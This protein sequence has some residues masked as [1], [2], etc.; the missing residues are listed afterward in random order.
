MIV[1]DDD[2]A[3]IPDQFHG[4]AFKPFRRLGPGFARKTAPDRRSLNAIGIV[5][6]AKPGSVSGALTLDA[7]FRQG[8]DVLIA[9]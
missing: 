5:I 6:P 9:G 8:D 7:G 3:G 1:V 2:G 4:E